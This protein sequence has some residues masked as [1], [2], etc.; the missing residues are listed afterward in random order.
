MVLLGK[1]TYQ[2]HSYQYEK[3]QEKR[4]DKLSDLSKSQD[5]E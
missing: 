3:E 1:W 5:S 4:G 2:E